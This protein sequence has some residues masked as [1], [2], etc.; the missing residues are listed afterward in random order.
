MKRAVMTE[1]GTIVFRETDRPVPGAHE[2]VMQTR[3]IGVCGSDHSRLPRDAPVVGAEK[4]VHSRL[5]PQAP[6]R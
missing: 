4:S 5:F 2:I 1:P 6:L 3:R